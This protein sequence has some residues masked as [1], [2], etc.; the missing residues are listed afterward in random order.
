MV[1]ASH[2]DKTIY[3]K[4]VILNIYAPKN[5]PSKHKKQKLIKLKEEL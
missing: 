4:I 2:D 5:K 1:G 3:R